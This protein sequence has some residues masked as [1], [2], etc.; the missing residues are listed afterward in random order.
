MCSVLVVEL[1]RRG[2]HWEGWAGNG[3]LGEKDEVQIWVFGLRT[4][5]VRAS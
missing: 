3:R 1:G 4:D 5:G 2:Y